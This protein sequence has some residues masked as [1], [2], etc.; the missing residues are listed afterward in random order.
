MY[1]VLLELLA[2]DKPDSVYKHSESHFR[3]LVRHEIRY[4]KDGGHYSAV[5]YTNGVWLSKSPLGPQPTI[6]GSFHL[7]LGSLEEVAC[8]T[9]YRDAQDMMR[10]PYMSDAV[11][12]EIYTRFDQK[13]DELARDLL[14]ARGLMVYDTRFT[15]TP[16]PMIL[17][18]V[19][20]G[21]R[22]YGTGAIDTFGNS[23]VLAH[24]GWDQAE[25]LSEKCLS[26]F[27]EVRYALHG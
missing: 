8:I 26:S 3:D 25:L 6:D 1:C 13:A 5:S 10:A 27:Q 17:A 16:Y 11:L 2:R 22:F 18:A 21:G 9:P 4:Q 14:E 23:R 20:E 24:T 7:C 15:M 12:G 19:G